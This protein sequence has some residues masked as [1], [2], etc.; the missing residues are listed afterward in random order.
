MP[1]PSGY[2]GDLTPAQTWEL[3]ANNPD[4]V[5]VDVRTEGEWRTIGVP[6]TSS[7]D[8]RPVFIEWATAWGPNPSF[9][10]ELTGSGANP[11]APIIFLCRSGGRSV[12]A[13]QDATAAGFT[14][15]FN[16]LEGF[17]GDL[18]AAGERT[19]NGWRLAGLP[20]TTFTSR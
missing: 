20:T 13:A 5:L 1:T 7:I 8:H 14:Q 16:V 19:V 15:A 12:G 4:A 3:L 17:E 10:K 6:D 2:A 18:D 9:V 11:A